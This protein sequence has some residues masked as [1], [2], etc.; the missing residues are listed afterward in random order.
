MGE[1]SNEYDKI[2]KDDKLDDLQ[3]RVRQLLDQVDQ[4]SKEQA[5]QRVCRSFIH[6]A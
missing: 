6:A 3:L 2:Q 4:I 1:A 5:Y